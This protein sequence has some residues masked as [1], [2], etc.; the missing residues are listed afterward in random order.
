VCVADQSAIPVAF[1][2]A[3]AGGVGSVVGE[4]GKEGRTEGAWACVPVCASAGCS[5]SRREF[6]SQADCPPWLPVRAVPAAAAAAATAGSRGTEGGICQRRTQ[7]HPQTTRGQ[8][9]VLLFDTVSC[10]RFSLFPSCS[11]RL[12]CPVPREAHPSI[13]FSV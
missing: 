1:L 2:R 12:C 8:D 9:S 11:V 5:A 4:Q 10:C 7:R 6:G 13:P 3:S